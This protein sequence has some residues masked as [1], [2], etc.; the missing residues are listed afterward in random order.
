MAVLNERRARMGLA[1]LG[2]PSDVD[3]GASVRSIGAVETW[4]RL[5][6]DESGS[7]AARR[8]RAVDLDEVEGETEFARARFVIPG[9]AEW[10]E[11]LNDLDDRRIEATGGVPYGLWV[12][13]AIRLDPQRPVA[14]TGARAATEYGM[15]VAESFAAQLALDS[16]TVIASLS[17][18]IEVA[19][20]RGALAQEGYAPVVVLG[21]GLHHM[22]LSGSEQLVAELDERAIVITEHA[23]SQPPSR[24]GFLARARLIAALSHVTVVVEAGQRSGARLTARWAHE[25]GRTVLAVPGPITS[26]T[27]CLPHELIQEGTAN[28]VTCADDVV[29][30][31]APCTSA[32]SNAVHTEGDSA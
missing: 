16:S 3:V 8:A 7:L 32:H 17:F 11:C 18:G 14:I 27:S 10:P 21:A 29:A 9:D 19:A 22:R 5:V 13:G 31:V 15:H 23:P 26:Y 28:L 25:L 1:S 30:A 4:T 20:I 12:R 2:L 6:A 24:A